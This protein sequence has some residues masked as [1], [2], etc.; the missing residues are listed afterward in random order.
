M[1]ESDTNTLRAPV[2]LDTRFGVLA[3]SYAASLLAPVI[4][5]VIVQYFQIRSWALALG[6]L[7]VTGAAICALFVLLLAES[8][9]IAGWLNDGWL[10]WTLPLLGFVPLFAHGFAVLE[11]LA[12]SLTEFGPESVGSLV[13]VVGFILAIA[14]CWLGEMMI[15]SARNRVAS[16][17]VADEPV[18]VEWTAAWPRADR[19]KVQ[20]VVL[21]IGFVLVGLLAVQYS[22]LTTV[23]TLPAVAATTFALNSIFANRVYRL[24]PSG[25]EQYQE[26]G[27]TTFRQFLAWSRFD[28]FSVTDEAFVLHRQSLRP[29]VRFSRKDVRLNEDSIRDAFRAHLDQ[30]D[31]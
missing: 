17:A 30:R 24:T 29:D 3:G 6:V 19:I 2:R 1:G 23:Y 7:G 26:A 28:A 15:R 22:V 14:A 21:L 12:Y 4:T 27:L 16:A 5:L 31:S 11:F 13:G 9:E 20:S 25:L 8:G 18:S 10:P